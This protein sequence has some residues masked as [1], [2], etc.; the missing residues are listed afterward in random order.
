VILFLDSTIFSE[1]PP[2]RAMWAPIGQQACVPIAGKHARRILTGVMNIRT[3][4]YLDFAS[5]E[6]HQEHFQ[7]I[8]RAIRRRWRGWRI[9]LFLDRN[10]PHKAGASRRLARELN[11]QL[12]WLPKACSELNVM[13]HLWRKVKDLIAANEPTP[14]VIATVNRARRTIRQ[15]TPKERLRKAGVL[16][17]DF[18]LADVLT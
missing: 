4:D 7:R 12:R 6:F 8:L 2:L 11:I 10:T 17:K 15:M 3:G 16:S 13:D 5:A 18:W 1:V 9:V 14:N